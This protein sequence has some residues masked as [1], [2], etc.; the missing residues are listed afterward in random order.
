MEPSSDA[1][2]PAAEPSRVSWIVQHPWIV[3][4]TVAVLALVLGAVVGD[5]R[6]GR[7]ADGYFKEILKWQEAYNRDIAEKDQ[8]H[9]KEMEAQ[10]KKTFAANKKYEDLRKQLKETRADAQKPWTPPK[11]LADTVERFRVLGY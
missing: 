8:I 2:V 3:V 9:E 10:R 4:V 6:Q 11:S 1:I 5:L 7:I